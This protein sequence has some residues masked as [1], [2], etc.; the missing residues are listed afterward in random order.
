MNPLTEGNVKGRMSEVERED[1]GKIRRLEDEKSGDVEG[2][3]IRRV[4]SFGDV[5]AFSFCQDK[6][7]TTGGE[8]GHAHHE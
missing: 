1:I 8:G 7:M 5:A 4:G 3:L 2:G 6:I